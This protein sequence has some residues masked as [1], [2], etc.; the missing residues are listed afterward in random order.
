MKPRTGP[1]STLDAVLSCPVSAPAL[2]G[3]ASTLLAASWVLVRRS[4]AALDG[5]VFFFELAGLATTFRFETVLV[6]FDVDFP[7]AT[8]FLPVEACF[9][10]VFFEVLFFPDALVVFRALLDAVRPTFL[11]LSPAVRLV[12]FREVFPAVLP[13]PVFFFFLVAAFLPGI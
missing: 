5:E 1:K 13:L 11:R 6:F 7:T 2:A 12:A 10:G 8:F 4:S 3:F 9:L